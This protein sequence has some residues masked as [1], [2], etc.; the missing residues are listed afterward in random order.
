VEVTA[1]ENTVVPEPVPPSET[2]QE[3]RE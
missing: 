2:S 3:T 1:P